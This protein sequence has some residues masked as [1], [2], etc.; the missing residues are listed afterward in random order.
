MNLY[1]VAIL[2]TI[3]LQAPHDH[4]HGHGHGHAGAHGHGRHGNPE[5]LESYLQRMESPE[6]AEWQKPDEVVAA[7]GLSAGQS[8]CEI[9]A[10]PGYFSLRI[11]QAVGER[12]AVYAVEVE[13]RIIEVLRERVAASGHR[14]VVPVLALPDDP[15][16]PVGACDLILMVNVFHHFADGEA[17]LGRLARSLKPGGR[18][19]NI[20]FHKRELPMGPPVED[21]IERGEFLKV[22][23]AAGF[24]LVAEPKILPHQYFLVLQ[25]R[26]R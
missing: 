11:A 12:G 9:G 19:V 21:K 24:E 20:D 14:N 26:K 22:A 8:V 5:D 17:Y 4:G 23:N 10:G 6:R 2:M 25:P 16:L 3:L 18:V 15:L 7:L 13:P 1:T